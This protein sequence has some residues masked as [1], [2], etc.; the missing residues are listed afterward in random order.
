MNRLGAR[1]Y[2]L[3]AIILIAG[4][5]TLTADTPTVIGEVREYRAETPH[6]NDADEQGQQN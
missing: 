4:I 6:R 2:L 1:G 3:V 5:T